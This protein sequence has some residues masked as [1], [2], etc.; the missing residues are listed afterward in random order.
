VALLSAL[1]RQTGDPAGGELLLTEAVRERVARARWA[2]RL[3]ELF[4]FCE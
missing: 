2:E 3:P 1:R 4:S